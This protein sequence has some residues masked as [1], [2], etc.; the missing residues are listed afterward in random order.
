MYLLN[1]LFQKTTWTMFDASV[2][3]R[4]NALSCACGLKNADQSIFTSPPLNI[5]KLFMA[6]NKR[7]Y[8]IFECSLAFIVGNQLVHYYLDP[9]RN[10]EDIAIEKK[11]QLW[12]NYLAEKEAKKQG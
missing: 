4:A 6:I 10:L 2:M 7:Y 3:T 1:L 5:M 8:H 9:L 11:N 12:S